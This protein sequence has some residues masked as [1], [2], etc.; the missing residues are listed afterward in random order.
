MV[1]SHSFD[2]ESR[3]VVGY[4]VYDFKTVLVKHDSIT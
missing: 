3:N 4:N 2:I 1:Y